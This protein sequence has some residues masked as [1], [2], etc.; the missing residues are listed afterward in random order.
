MFPKCLWNNGARFDL[1]GVFWDHTIRKLID[2]QN[3]IQLGSLINEKFFPKITHF[4]K[5]T[6]IDA[7]VGYDI[8][9]CSKDS[10]KYN[11]FNCHLAYEMKDI[12]ETQ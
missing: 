9:N 4:G 12:K 5:V 2:Q 11:K 8:G 3:N 10:D 7:P 6:L 1:N